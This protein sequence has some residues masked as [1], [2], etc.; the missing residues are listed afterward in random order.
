MEKF[1]EFRDPVTGINPFLMPKRR[2]ITVF[3]ILRALLYLPVY[4]L[5]KLRLPVVQVLFR[6][7]TSIANTNGV[8]A[9]TD[10]A[11]TVSSKNRLTGR[12]YAN[13]VSEFDREIIKYA[14]G[15][16]NVIFP[17]G[18]TTNNRGILNYKKREDCEGVIGLKYSSDCIYLYGSKL[19]W[20][21]CFLGGDKTVEIRWAT[22]SDL[23]KAAGVPYLG[24]EAGDKNKFMSKIANQ[25][26]E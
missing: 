14:C 5:F 19:L 2:R 3:T 18:A 16:C 1:S 26:V 20:L 17:E 9:N 25:K 10:G 7:K 6:I 24:L 22:G 4:L 15:P 11:S 13:S 8:I 12:I 23:S 21:I